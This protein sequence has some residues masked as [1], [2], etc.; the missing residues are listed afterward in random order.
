M[1][2]TV[3]ATRTKHKARFVQVWEVFESQK[4]WSPLGPILYTFLCCSWG[5]LN[6]LY[7]YIY[8]YIIL[9][10]SLI[11]LIYFIMQGSARGRSPKA[12]LVLQELLIWPQDNPRWPPWR[13]ST[14]QKKKNIYI[15]MLCP[16]SGPSFFE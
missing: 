4:C 6:G 8:L 14:Y 15:Y 13:H 11:Y 7:I 5:F 3:V 16:V 1:A 2:K 9:F 12:D 10:I